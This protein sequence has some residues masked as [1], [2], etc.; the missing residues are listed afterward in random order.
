[1]AAAQA[2]PVISGTLEWAGLRG[3]LLRP[4]TG[5][6]GKGMPGSPEVRPPA[7]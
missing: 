6:W 5:L 1:M 4:W 7:L 2:A 3:A